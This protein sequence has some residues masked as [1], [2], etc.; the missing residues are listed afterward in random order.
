[1]PEF[2]FATGI[3]CSYPTVPTPDGGRRRV[4]Q[5]ECCYHYKRWRE[6]FELLKELGLKYLRYGPPYYKCHVGP[7][8]YD[9]SFPDETLPVLRDMGIT[10]LADLCHFGVPDW[11]GNF[12]NDEWPHYF[13]EYSEAFVQR[14][15]W[16]DIFTPVNE[17][18]VATLFSGM[19]GWWNEALTSDRG[20]VRALKNLCEAS[21]RSMQCIVKLKPDAMF[22]QSE[23]TEYFH[24]EN[25]ACLDHAYFLNER[26][27]LPLDLTYSYPI[28]ARMYRY[29]M[30]NGMTE[31][32][33]DWLATNHVRANC[34]MGNDYYKRNEHMVHSDGTHDA[35]G[36]IF[37]Y[38]VITN[39][40]YQRY[41]L[42]TMHTETNLA[43]PEAV[44]WLKRSWANAH[45]LKEDGLPLLGFTWYSLTDQV[46]WDSALREDNGNVN[47]LGLCTLDRQIRPVGHEY[48]KLIQEWQSVIMTEDQSLSTRRW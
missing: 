43:E 12:Q 20:Y 9:W 28:T 40:Y 31:E 14:Y 4:D 7:G 27:F 10:V 47:P 26:R 37:G 44:E 8:Q 25:P 29:L 21:I 2:M 17:M 24:S 36:D 11:L 16:I 32:E 19:Y 22:V 39:Q 48:K 33:F 30:D 45:R 34:V 23:S 35:A 13:T 38:Y 18:S 6:D 1:M 46:D 5:M 3:E 15:P 42:P 41:R